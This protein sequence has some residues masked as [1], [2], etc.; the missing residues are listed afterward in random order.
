MRFPQISSV[1]PLLKLGGVLLCFALIPACGQKEEI[2]AEVVPDDAIARVGEVWITTA[3]V[4]LVLQTGRARDADTA[5][6]QII[7][8][9]LLAHAAMEAGLNQTPE[10]R[11]TWRQMLAGRIRDA[12]MD[13]LSSPTDAQLET[14]HAQQIERFTEPER[15]A[16]A[17]L[18]R[19]FEE[20]E[21]ASAVA[22][23]EEARKRFAERE[24]ELA[25]T[26]FGPEA[27][28]YSDE[29]DTRFNG[30]LCGWIQRDQTHFL[31]PPEVIAA[32]FELSDIGDLSPVVM[33]N[34]AAWLL[35][36]TN[37]RPATIRPVTEVADL[38]RIEWYQAQ[39]QRAFEDL[40]SQTRKT[41]SVEIFSKE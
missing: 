20:V 6:Q 3:D 41:V 22:A 24:P 19:Q 31:L 1:Y 38:L 39:Q 34:D 21:G 10:F 2:E 11:A 40:L 25:Q 27:A 12:S 37:Q 5:R 29:P 4:D 13:A 32:A 33:A 18:R 9:L 30:G 35:L 7:D 23:L 26:G 36:L 28:R 17:V 15:K 8:E 16:I 14:L